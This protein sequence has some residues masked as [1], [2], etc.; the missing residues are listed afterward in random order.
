MAEDVADAA[1]Y[2]ATRPLHVDIE[3]MII[4]PTVQ[5]SANHLSRKGR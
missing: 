1:L 5:A 2:C 4:M 3:Q